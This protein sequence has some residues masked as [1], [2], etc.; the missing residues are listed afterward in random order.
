MIAIWVQGNFLRVPKH[1][2]QSK[3]LFFGSKGSHWNRGRFIF[4]NFWKPNLKKKISLNSKSDFVISSGCSNFF[5]VTGKLR[6]WK[7]QYTG[8]LS[9]IKLSTGKLSTGNLSTGKLSTGNLSTGKLSN[10]KLSTRK[11]RTGNLSTIRK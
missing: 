4:I 7:T 3:L 5:S 10:G 11:L 6:T 8:K 2:L 1:I 9:K